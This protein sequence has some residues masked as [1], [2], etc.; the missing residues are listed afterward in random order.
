LHWSFG[1]LRSGTLNWR[2]SCLIA[3]PF[4]VLTLADDI[5][6]LPMFFSGYETTSPMSSY[7]IS[8]CNR[9]LQGAFSHYAYTVM[10]FVFS[11]AALKM[12]ASTFNLQR[13]CRVLFLPKDL[14]ERIERKRIWVDS[15]IIATAYIAL[16]FLIT[17]SASWVRAMFSPNFPDDSLSAICGIA[18][19]YSPNLDLLGDTLTSGVNMLTTVVFIAALYK[20]YC[21]NFWLFLLFATLLKLITLASNRYWQD[22]AIDFVSQLIALIL[23]WFV[24]RKLAGY[25][26]LVYFL[27]G[28]GDLVLS[29]LL[30]LLDHGQPLF[31]ND[32]IFTA[33]LLASP[34]AFVC[35]LFINTPS[36]P[37]EEPHSAALVEG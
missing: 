7:I 30:I 25:N 34:F 24:I 29:R 22:F 28:A 19:I 6:A 16:N 17:S 37:E 32:A 10:T 21:R 35:Y 3:L 4:V 14:E 36:A 9:Y 12:L 5:N 1:V 20:K 8:A 13:F 33:V 31:F 23:A 27:A 18:N 11:L 15:V 2:Q 26:P